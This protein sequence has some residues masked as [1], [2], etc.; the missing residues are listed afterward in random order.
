MVPEVMVAPPI[1]ALVMFPVVPVKTV[2]KKLDEEAEPISAM[3]R[4]D[5]AEL[6]FWRVEEANAMIP[7]VVVGVRK[8]ETTLQS[9]KEEPRSPREDVAVSAYVPPVCPTRSCPYVGSVESPV[10][11]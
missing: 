8:P 9:V 7:I 10:P 2:E 4:V 6:K 3:P 1:N 5:D 11:P